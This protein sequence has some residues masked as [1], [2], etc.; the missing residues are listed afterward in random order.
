MISENSLAT[1]K[2]RTASTIR[3]VAIF[4]FELLQLLNCDKPR[5]FGE[6]D[7]S[8]SVPGGRAKCGGKPFQ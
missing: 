7:V 6:D 8:I 5:R 4:A 1:A 3:E 2:S